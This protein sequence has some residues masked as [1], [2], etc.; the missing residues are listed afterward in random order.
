MPPS[1]KLIVSPYD[2]EA[3]RR[4]KRSTSWDGYV[5]HLTETCDEESPNLITHVTTTPATTGDAKVLSDIH[6]KLAA[7]GLLPSEHLVDTGYYDT[8]TIVDSEARPVE[9]VGPVIPNT[10]WQSR[11][12][13]AYDLNYFLLIGTPRR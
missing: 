11:D 8:Q 3:R 10:S 2:P 13:E 9:M 5:G 1:K 7:K 6:Q 12:E 4:V